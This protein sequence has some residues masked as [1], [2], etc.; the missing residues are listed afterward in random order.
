MMT[1]KDGKQIS[2]E[3]ALS[4][5]SLKATLRLETLNDKKFAM[6]NGIPYPSFEP[7][8]R[9][10]LSLQ[11]EWKKRRFQADHHWTMLERTEGWISKT[12]EL[13]EGVTSA[14]FDDSEWERKNLPHPE[15]TLTGKQEVN[16][17]ET[18]EDGVWYRRSFELN[19]EWENKVLTLKCLGLSYVG[20]FWLNGEYVGYHEGGYTPFAFDISSF[21]QAGENT[22][23][24]RVDNPPWTSRYDTVPATDNDF[25]NYTGLLQ[26]IYIER[27]KAAHVVRVDV[28]PEDVNGKVTIHTV[29]EN[30]TSVLRKVILSP[31]FFDTDTSSENW[32]K[33]P[34]AKSICHQ[35]IEVAGLREEELQLSPYETKVV[36]YSAKINRPNLWSV[37]VPNLYVAQVILR[38]KENN[39]IIDRFY[40]QFGIRTITTEKTQICLNDTP[41]FLAGIARHEEWPE[42]GRT[43][44]WSRILS[45]FLSI[46]QLQINMVRTAHYPNHVYTFIVL[47]R[48]G[49]TAMSE[50]P[51]W[52][53]EKEHYEVQE[54]RQISYQM[55]R[56][57][58]FSS[59]NRPSIIMWSTQNESKDSI[60]RKKYNETLANEVRS[61]YD[62]K[63]LLTQS[64]AADQPGFEDETMTCLDVAGWTMYFGIFHGSTPYE[65]TRNFIERAHEKWPDK[66]ILN[67]E[68]GIW[69]NAD[70]SYIEK[71]VDIYE[72]V[73]LALLEK[74]TVT[75]QGACNRL[76]YLAGMDYWTVFDWYVNHN[77]FYQTMGIYHMDRQLK[78]PLYDE[79]VK[80]HKRLMGDHHGLRNTEE[81]LPSIKLT[82]HGEN[83]FSYQFQELT[84]IR[85][86]NYLRLTVYDGVSDK[87]FRVEF[88]G[89]DSVAAYDTF[90][91]EIGT[92]FD[93]FVPLWKLEESALTHLS[94]IK[95]YT[96]GRDTLDIREVHLTLIGTKH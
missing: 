72:D 62:D 71:Q 25:F 12:E 30:R 9:L 15:N 26:D 53:F 41:I 37:R 76:G 49:L 92:E 82:A 24:I 75:P 61:L 18:Y 66:P 47:D 34:S 13:S 36:T 56:E 3:N 85:E 64:A 55:W 89:D 7:Q 60:L 77:K 35:E 33:E 42:H 4:E 40:T 59:Y 65:G 28:I 63:R 79:F 91:L 83:K 43:A 88:V 50:I 95:V 57:M 1:I 29:I 93:V 67:T 70:D 22:I 46:S 39:E 11:G 10:Q 52:Q 17:A 45:D 6:Q 78:K 84:D 8:D 86:Y 54:K 69:S 94:E 81:L 90:K 44:T 20:D 51:L 27:T 68:Y 19:G 31:T 21:V 80:D 96:E 74:A 5:I 14:A 87:G 73:Q 58:I 2:Y 38:L 23:V 48:L 16:G 32:L